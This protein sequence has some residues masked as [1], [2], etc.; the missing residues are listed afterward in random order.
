MV[1]KYSNM[2]VPN[3]ALQPTPKSGEVINRV[4]LE[5]LDKCFERI[6]HK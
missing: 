5:L 6:G 2:L 3:K 1:L 4:R